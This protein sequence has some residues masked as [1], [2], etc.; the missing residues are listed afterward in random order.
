MGPTYPEL[1]SPRGPAAEFERASTVMWAREKAEDP[2]EDLR[3]FPIRRD[4]YAVA[5]DA[6]AVP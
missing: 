2:V 6:V 4:T 1:D 3:E 5:G